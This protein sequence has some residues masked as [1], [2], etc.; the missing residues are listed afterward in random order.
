M[1]VEI[2]TW[3]VYLGLAYAGVG[4]LFALPFVLKGAQSIDPAAAD[5]TRGF[6]ILIFPGAALLWPLLAKRWMSGAGSPPEERSPH[7]DA[8]RGRGGAA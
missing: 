6:R 2:A 3:I 5:G 8:A 1:P 7:R 4:V